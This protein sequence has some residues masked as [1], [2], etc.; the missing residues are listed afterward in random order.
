MLN[1]AAWLSPRVLTHQRK[2]PVLNECTNQFD[3]QVTRQTFPTFSSRTSARHL[4]E[5]TITTYATLKLL[6]FYELGKL[7]CNLVWKISERVVFF[8]IFLLQ[9]YISCTQL[10][11][12]DL[13]RHWPS[14]TAWRCQQHHSS[15]HLP[16]G[17]PRTIP[18]RSGPQ[19]SIHSPDHL[20]YI[21]INML[22]CLMQTPQPGLG[23]PW[24]KNQLPFSSL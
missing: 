16:E 6:H 3:P 21:S 10:P 8:F 19:I 9:N 1:Q 23:N 5:W 13:L 17:A 18:K 12:S 22:L 14:K 2:H 24:R 15:V 11:T 20:Q 7:P 4:M